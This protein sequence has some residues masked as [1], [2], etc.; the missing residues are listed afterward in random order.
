MPS[1]Q[2]AGEP[3]AEA[4]T[5]ADTGADTAPETAPETAPDPA[6]GPAPDP[7]ADR[8]ASPRDGWGGDRGGARG[9][10][11]ALVLGLLGAIGLTVG[12]SRSW[13]EATATVARLPTIHT[14]ASGATLAPVAGAFGLVTLAA[15]GAVIATRGW[16][17]RA[18]GALIVVAALVA[19]VAVLHPGDP[20]GTLR[21]NLT[22]K[23]WT[24]GG[25]ASSTTAWRWLALASAL[26][27]AAAGAATARLGHR[28]AVMG[29]RY[30][31]PT[32]SRRPVV[33]RPEEMRES[34][35]WQAI[36]RGDD[37]TS[38]PRRD[39]AAAESQ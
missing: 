30:D 25:Y 7:A 18:L 22:D 8:E 2:T 10:G 33:L 6:P 27:C 26:V 11:A 4:D 32:R 28:W 38:T 13:A 19:A 37:P 34:D 21:S 15:F 36:D 12:A 39:D 14:S 16:V 9:Y 3:A 17:R 35:V 20:D 29:A 31:A 1:P 5:G 24:G 23:G